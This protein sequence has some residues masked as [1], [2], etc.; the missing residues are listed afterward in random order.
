M[1]RPYFLAG[2]M[3][4]GAQAEAHGGIS[5]LGGLQDGLLGLIGL[6]G[7]PVALMMMVA[8]WFRKKGR[9][10]GWKIAI[11]IVLSC[12][13]AL[14]TVPL[15]FGLQSNPWAKF[16]G[17]MAAIVIAQLCAYFLADRKRISIAAL[18]FVGAIT[19]VMLAIPAEFWKGNAFDLI[20]TIYID[21]SD[22]LQ[23]VTVL[24]EPEHSRQ[25]LFL[26]DG[27]KIL[28]FE[29][30]DAESAEDPF[31]YAFG[32]LA[33]L[34]RIATERAGQ[35]FTVTHYVRRGDYVRARMRYGPPPRHSLFK[36]TVGMYVPRAQEAI[37]VL[38]DEDAGIDHEAM[39][40]RILGW[41]G[42]YTLK[43]ELVALGDIDINERSFVDKAFQSRY[44]AAYD[45]L[46]D[47]DIDVHTVDSKGN[48]ILHRVAETGSLPLMKRLVSRG[49]SF[50]T[51]NH[52]G[53]NPAEVFHT[54]YA[55]RPDR[56]RKFRRA[57]PQATP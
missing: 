5:A 12:L 49:A 45:F 52:Q 7:I 1:P 43:K 41:S 20:E 3:L 48:T 50:D 17:A 24:N 38:L 6:I 47:M 57:F 36:R 28:Q 37:G 26:A 55:K 14:F 54:R 15:Y 16:P 40:L 33:S 21:N 32:Q 18:T 9:R 25:L 19:V 8:A 11:L 44:L 27:R 29:A 10:G 2:L 4:A 46:A 39:L 30:V 34:S 42:A 31:T 35:W 22:E 56:I 13:Y 53:V 23:A 51:A